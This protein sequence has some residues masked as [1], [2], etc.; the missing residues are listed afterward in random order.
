VTRKQLEIV[1]PKFRFQPLDIHALLP[2]GRIRV[3]RVAACLQ[4]LRDAVRE[5]A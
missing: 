3:P 2:Q 4:V 5:L 1:L